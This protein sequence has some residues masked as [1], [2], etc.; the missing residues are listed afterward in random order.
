MKRPTVLIVFGGESSEHDVSIQSAKNVFAATDKNKYETLLG[1]IDRNGRW[2][3]LDG[4][5][6]QL[7]NKHDT[8]LVVAPGTGTIL[9]VPGSQVIHIDVLFPVLHGK[10]GEDGTIQGLADMAHIPVVGCG[11]ESSAVCMDKNATKRLIEGFDIPVVPWEIA[12]QADDSKSVMKKAKSLSKTGPWFVKPA[13]AGSSVGVSRVTDATG[14][15]DA[16]VLALRHD[17]IVLIEPAITGRELE[18]SVIG[19]P[20]NHK[21]S[22]IGEIISGRDFY[23]YD[24]KYSPESTSKII[25]DAT[26][27]KA[28]A[29]TIR[30]YAADTYEVLGCRG[31]AR[32][33]FLLSEDN[34]VYVNEINTMPGFTDISMYPKLWAEKGVSYDSLIDQLIGLTLK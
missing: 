9:T 26:L 15:Y 8:Q 2:W 33:D 18:V 21:A 17:N 6:D 14:L 10:Y 1:Y 19:N 34:K 32:V 28:I 29:K 11:V 13:R 30:R 4:W 7:D 23:D 5:T 27:P 22:G 3:L 25:L 12:G 16:V 24:D 31:L 20:P